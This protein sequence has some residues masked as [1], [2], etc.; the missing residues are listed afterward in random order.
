MED[1]IFENNILF[2]LLISTKQFY[3][4]KNSINLKS[5]PTND[6]HKCHIQDTKYKYSCFKNPSQYFMEQEY[7]QA[8]LLV[9]LNDNPASNI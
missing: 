4:F 1:F 6:L 3:Y 5:I 2:S 7:G 9:D 8:R